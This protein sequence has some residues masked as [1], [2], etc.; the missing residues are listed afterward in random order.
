M[1][2]ELNKNKTKGEKLKRKSFKDLEMDEVHH[3]QEIIATNPETLGEEFLIIQKEYHGFDDTNERL[4]LLALDKN[5]NLVVIENKLDD[6]GKDVTWQIIKYASY[7]STFTTDDIIKVFQEYLDKNDIEENAEEKLKEFYEIEKIEELIL[8]D[9][10]TSQRL[11]LVA[12][13]FRKEITSSVLWLMNY[14][15]NIQC[16]KATPYES[17]EKV[18]LDMQQ[19]IPVKDVEDFT[20]K[21]S[22]KEKK[23]EKVK[24]D[25]N[26]VYF[27]DD[28]LLNS[29]ENVKKWY[30]NLWNYIYEKKY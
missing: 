26:K 18:F 11:I 20:I 22:E 2:F 10:N 25:L 7:V 6:S 5:K 30:S 4:D 29:N 12:G 21:I 3:L 16:I 15:L 14:G 9:G 1:L 27:E 17:E 19:I 24:R 8:N 13:N 23:N 28:L